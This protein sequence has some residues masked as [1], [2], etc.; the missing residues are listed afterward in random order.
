MGSLIRKIKCQKRHKIAQYSEP[1]EAEWL[2]IL[3]TGCLLI[4][5]DF[6]YHLKKIQQRCKQKTQKGVYHQVPRSICQN[7]FPS[8]ESGIPFANKCKVFVLGFFP[9]F[10]LIPKR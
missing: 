1:N 7:N 2:T 4:D 6:L 8:P 10:V 9:L 3:E 5:F